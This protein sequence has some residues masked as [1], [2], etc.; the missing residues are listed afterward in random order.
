ML[1][2]LDRLISQETDMPGIPYPMKLELCC[3]GQTG[4]IAENTIFTARL[5]DL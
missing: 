2:N 5:Y 1:R 4:I 3:F